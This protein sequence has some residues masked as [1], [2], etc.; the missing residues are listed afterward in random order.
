M[1]KE[2][3]FAISFG[4]VLGVLAGILV[5]FQARH[6]EEAKVIPVEAGKE[7]VNEKVVD[8]DSIEEQLVIVSPSTNSVFDKDSFELSGE[9]P[10]N[11]LVVIQ[12]P[13]EELV[14]KNKEKNFKKEVKLALGENVINISVY[15]GNSV[16]EEVIRIY[17]IKE[18]SQ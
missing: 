3:I 2:T 16:Q 6:S 15:S 5:L 11:G 12:T 13:I 18:E 8:L 4:V 10:L 14:F 7:V 9:A 17:Y 1:K